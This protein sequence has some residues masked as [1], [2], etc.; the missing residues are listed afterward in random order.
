M[1]ISE[2]RLKSLANTNARANVMV[3]QWYP[4]LF[5]DGEAVVPTQMGIIQ[6]LR[7]AQPVRQG[8]LR[9]DVGDRRDANGDILVIG[10]WYTDNVNHLMLYEGDL[11]NS[12]G[13]Y[14]G[15][16]GSTWSFP[17]PESSVPASREL[18]QSVLRQEC[19]NRGYNA[20]NFLSFA[21]NYHRNHPIQV[22]YYDDVSDS[23]YAAP[24]GMGGLCMYKKGL[25]ADINNNET[26]IEINNTPNDNQWWEF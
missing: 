25:W 26:A 15:N 3:K 24:H 17:H 23:M 2:T 11:T 18:V 19:I 7:E 8:T 14:D 1:E 10:R 4:D 6:T 9:R 5:I 16:W 20:S 21:G 13:F 22:W 12:K